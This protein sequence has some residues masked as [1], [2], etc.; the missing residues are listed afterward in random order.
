MPVHLH[1]STLEYAPPKAD[2]A[3]SSTPEQ[4]SSVDKARRKRRITIITISDSEDDADQLRLPARSRS[5]SQ[6]P[7]LEN[8]NHSV[9]ANEL[10]EDVSF[11]DYS[12]AEDAQAQATIKQ[13]A[14]AATQIIEIDSSDSDYDS[15]AGV[16]VW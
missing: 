15:A 10:T 14:E 8:E 3:I 6:T 13:P 12:D 16:I 4:K 11:A 9:E 2:R 5:P 1:S 7:S